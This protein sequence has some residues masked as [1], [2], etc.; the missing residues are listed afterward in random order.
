MAQLSNTLG[1]L[2]M[3]RFLKNYFARNKTEPQQ[4]VLFF[5]PMKNRIIPL[6]IFLF[7]SSVSPAQ[8]WA[9]AEAFIRNTLEVQL[10]QQEDNQKWIE[11]K[12]ALEAELLAAE[13]TKKSLLAEIEEVNQKLK[14]SAENVAIEQAAQKDTEEKYLALQAELKLA[15]Q[16]IAKY[17]DVVTPSKEAELLIGSVLDSVVLDDKQPLSAT[18]DKILNVHQQIWQLS[19][20]FQITETTIQVGE[21]KVH[22]YQIRLGLIYHFFLL[23]DNKQWAYFHKEQKKWVFGQSS[24]AEHLLKIYRVLSKKMPP[25]LTR[26]PEVNK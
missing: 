12:R 5:L 24:E 1:R 4:K 6:V 22:G 23:A 14:T 26:L 3:Y 19:Q 8:D 2:Q 17:N 9:N 13:H 11:E 21:Q 18:F 10:K 15:L 7:F 16:N 20:S 25:E